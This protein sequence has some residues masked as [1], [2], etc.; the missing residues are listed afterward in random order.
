MERTTVIGLWLGRRVHPTTNGVDLPDPLLSGVT[1]K[2]HR[3]WC[4]RYTFPL[5]WRLAVSSED[6]GSVQEVPLLPLRRRLCTSF[7]SFR[8]TCRVSSVSLPRQSK[9]LVKTRLITTTEFPGQDV[10]GSMLLP[11][12][13]QWDVHTLSEGSSSSG[14]QDVDEEVRDWEVV[15]YLPLPE[16]HTLLERWNLCWIRQPS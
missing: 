11:T 12:G 8:V 9:I 4:L 14:H 10:C 16:F 5:P 1:K 2:G 13:G 15:F 6:D 7:P 3:R